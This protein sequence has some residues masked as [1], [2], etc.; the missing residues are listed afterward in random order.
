MKS[1]KK[2]MAL[3]LAM[4]MMLAM[5][6]TAM[7]ASI[8]ITSTTDT[9]ATATET[10]EYT[11]YQILI[12]DMDSD[13]TTDTTTGQVSGEGVAYYVE[14][15]ALAN[16]IAA[17]GAFTVGNASTASD[18]STRYYVELAEGKDIED[19]KTALATLVAAGN[20]IGS[21]TFAQDTPGGTATADDLDPGYYYITSTLGDKVV[22]DTLADVTINTK[23][24]YPGVEKEIAEDDENSEIGSLVTYT[25]T[26]TVPDS[27]NDTIVLTD[28]MS[29]GLD[30]S[31][32]ESVK[33]NADGNPDVTYTL[34]PT[35]PAKTDKTFT[36]TFDAETV[37]ANKG[38][39]I[40]ITYKA[41]VNED[42]EIE[43]DIPNQVVLDYGNNYTS[44]PSK[45]NTKTYKA[46]F[47]KVDGSSNK[48]AGAKFQLKKGNTVM[49]LVEVTKGSEYRVATPDEIT[50]GT[51]IVTEMETTGQT[52]T[53][54]GLDLDE[55]YAL[56]ETKAPEGFNELEGDYTLTAGSDT[57]VHANIVNQKGSVLPSTGG[58]GTTIFYIIGAILVLGAGILL[59]TRRRMNAN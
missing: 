11:W 55:T 13:I 21:D 20:Y 36:I 34:N 10:T 5:A 24:S 28:T 14:T 30:F 35:A 37:T 46:T 50:A 18:G 19:V 15:E 3:A 39:T 17:T 49:S 26:V 25:L 44:V 27:A 31:S 58:I 56:H 43:T 8:T 32:I 51:G 42:A 9:D 54:K 41:M 59:V 29:S 52:I 6:S 45:V 2:M 7:A 57:F 40:T 53:I 16:A 4:V 48:L 38:K 12:A 33:S 1:L 47:D 22:V 23:N